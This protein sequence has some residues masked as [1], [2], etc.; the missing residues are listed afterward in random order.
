MNSPTHDDFAPRLTPVGLIAEVEHVDFPRPVA[1]LGA[2]LDRAARRIAASRMPAF[3]WL[4]PFQRVL[5]RVTAQKGEREENE[6][7]DV[8][9]AA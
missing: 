7:A 2:R 8:A 1:T 6:T 3:A 4:R 9:G 5:E